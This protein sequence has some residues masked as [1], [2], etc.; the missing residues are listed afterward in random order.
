MRF[1]LMEAVVAIENSSSSTA[2]VP[3]DGKLHKTGMR[4]S[5]RIY[6]PIFTKSNKLQ[7]IFLIPDNANVILQRQAGRWVNIHESALN[8]ITASIISNHW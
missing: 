5:E 4:N 7:G 8:S 6:I 3:P 1:R 2:V